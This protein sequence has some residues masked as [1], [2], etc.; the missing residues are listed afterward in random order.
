MLYFCLFASVDDYAI[1]P[2]GYFETGASK[3]ELI[4]INVIFVLELAI[5]NRKF[6]HAVEV[7]KLIV[8]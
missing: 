2:L 4:V 8:R 1:D 5:F 3:H 7:V 6:H